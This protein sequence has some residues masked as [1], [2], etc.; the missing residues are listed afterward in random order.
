MARPGWL[1]LF[2][3]IALSATMPG[4]VLAQGEQTE[5]DAD[6]IHESEAPDEAGA[7]PQRAIRVQTSIGFGIATLAFVRPTPTGV[8]RLP[9]TAFAA[10]ELSLRVHVK[11]EA[12][13]S[14]EVRVAYRTSV[15]FVLQ[16]EP[17]FALPER[18]DVRVQH[19]ELSVAPIVRLGGTG[20]MPVLA[21]PIG[22]AF[23]SFSPTVHQYPV[24]DYDLGG[25]RAGAELW[26][27]LGE[28]IELRAGPEVQW[29]ALIDASLR[30]AGACCQGV[31]VGGQ[32]AIQATIGE[33]L[34]AAL[35]YHESHGFVP[36]G[37]WRFKDVERFLALQIAGEL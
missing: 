4:L 7:T 31:S 11:P 6:A 26:I 27:P 28:R 3:V 34:R 16:L 15:G 37:G 19:V 13:L 8:Q 17:L 35:A 9:D 33:R 25:P 36:S 29:L 22:L 10:T 2:A 30:R 21:F 12:A 32:A 24:F 14:V 1:L 20:H 23:R 18:V 5:P